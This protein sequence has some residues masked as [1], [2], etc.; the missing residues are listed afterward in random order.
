MKS[1]KNKKSIIFSF[2]VLLGS[3]SILSFLVFSTIKESNRD[4]GKSPEE[5]D[6]ISPE[7]KVAYIKKISNEKK[8]EI[9]VV[10]NSFINSGEEVNIIKNTEDVAK[11]SGVSA[12]ISSVAEEKYIDGDFKQGINIRVEFSGSWDSI[13]RFIQGMEKVSYA[14]DIRSLTYL[15]NPVTGK[16][17]GD[18]NFVAYKLI[19]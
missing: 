17:S 7:E 2:L 3:L 10:N 11:N 1:L 6:N 8:D 9:S 15:K 12:S 19:K 16:W 5:V 13:N 4:N 14:I 18:L